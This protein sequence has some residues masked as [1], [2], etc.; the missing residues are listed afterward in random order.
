ML[1]IVCL[2]HLLLLLLV[3]RLSTGNVN[4]QP[5]NWMADVLWAGKGCYLGEAS[6]HY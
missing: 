1:L 3:V 2:T 5:I 6:V 4:T